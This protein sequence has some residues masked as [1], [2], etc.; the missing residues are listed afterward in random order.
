MRRQE[1]LILRDDP[2]LVIGFVGFI[3]YPMV[4]VP[5]LYAL[6]P[7]LG[8]GVGRFHNFVQMFTRDN[9]FWQPFKVTVLYVLGSVPAGTL[10]AGGGDDPAQ[11]CAG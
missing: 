11:A 5:R 3:A 4:R 2:A 1:A 8:P 7:A 6:Q 10:F 9:L